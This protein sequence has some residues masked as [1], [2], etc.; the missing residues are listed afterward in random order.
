MIYPDK[1]AESCVSSGQNQYGS[2][3]VLNT[4]K[5]RKSKSPSAVD[6]D[7]VVSERWGLFS[8]STLWAL[9]FVLPIIAGY[10]ITPSI[11]ANI[12]PFDPRT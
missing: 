7:L 12:V 5:V 8:A 1:R 3:R 9:V 11:S 2:K 10:A 6:Q 4:Q